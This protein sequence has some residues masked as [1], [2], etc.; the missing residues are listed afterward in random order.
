LEALVSKYTSSCRR[1]LGQIQITGND[2]DGKVKQIIYLAKCYLDDAEFYRSKDRL[3]VSLA[4]VAYSE[5]LLDALR[6][7]GTVEFS[8]EKKDET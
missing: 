3:D 7:L 2:F 5:G 6:L 1:V 8:W 4:S